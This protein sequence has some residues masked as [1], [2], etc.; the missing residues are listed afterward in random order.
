MAEVAVEDDAIRVGARFTVA[1]LRTLRVPSDGSTYPL[2][3]ALGRLPI[4]R[5]EQL[6]KRAPRSM[7][8]RGGFVVPLYQREALWLAFGGAHWKPNAVQVGVGGVN[9]I[10]AEPWDAELGANPQNYLVTPD[11]PWL[12]GI[13]AGA[14]YVRQFVALQLGRGATVEGQ[15]TEAERVGGI[16]LRVY[17]PVAGRFPERAPDRD[18]SPRAGRAHASPQL[19]VAAGGKVAQKIYPDSHG[20]ETWDRESASSLFVQLVNSE[21]YRALADRDPP[22]SPVSASLYT[23]HGLPW[24]DLYDERAGDVARSEPLAGL[25]PVGD[26]AEPLVIDPRQVR[27]IDPGGDRGEED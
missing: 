26:E 16:Q 21:Q 4:L 17:E 12:D 1:F 5:A 2:P 9:A 14:G 25:E 23:E 20:H 10:S 6:G 15:L 11:Q 3:P 8:E 7:R 27:P 19:G 18:D 13:N 24:F 22:P